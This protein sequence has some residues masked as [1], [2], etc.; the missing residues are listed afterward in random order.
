MPACPLALEISD[1]LLV[2]PF[3]VG[4]RHREEFTV[5][6][7]RWLGPALQHDLEGLFERLTVPFLILDRRAIGAAQRFVLARLIAAA[8]AALDAAAADHVEQRDLL[9]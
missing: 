8:D 7:E 1:R 4:R 9:G 6:R 5:M 3:R 2:V